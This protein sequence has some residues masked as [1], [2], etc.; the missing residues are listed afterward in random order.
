MLFL[1][2]VCV[3]PISCVKVRRHQ[4]DFYLM[5]ILSCR[6]VSLSFL[7]LLLWLIFNMSCLF[8]LVISTFTV[9]HFIHTSWHYITLYKL[10]YFS[11]HGAC[12][13]H[14]M[15]LRTS[16][17]NLYLNWRLLSSYFPPGVSP[18]ICE[19]VTVWQRHV[20]VVT[21]GM[22]FL[23]IRVYLINPFRDFFC[24]SYPSCIRTE[25]KSIYRLKSLKRILKIK[26]CR[27][28][29]RH[30]LMTVSLYLQT[31]YSASPTAAKRS[32]N[33]TRLSIHLLLPLILHAATTLAQWEHANNTEKPGS[34]SN[35]GL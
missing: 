33:S 32:F 10:G 22:L 4:L 2:D 7:A 28:R 26:I 11:S 15:P 6:L 21:G 14:V 16:I 13:W 8:F 18:R 30:E 31:K 24:Y 25:C 29:D 12:G 5:Q 3:K 23:S 17:L 1:S 19:C 20:T 35:S 27:V 9:H 34:E